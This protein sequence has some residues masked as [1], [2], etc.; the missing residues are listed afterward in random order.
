MSDRI[1]GRNIA[2][3]ATDGFEQSELDTPLDVLREAGARVDVIAPSKHPIQGLRHRERGQLVEVDDVIGNV[4]CIDYD[5][6]VIPG[7]LFSPDQ[8]RTD[9]AIIEFVRAF[10]DACKP[11]AAVCHGPWVLINACAVKGR[12]MTSVP[13]IRRDLENAGARWEDVEVDVDRGLITSRTPED[14]DAF[15]QAIITALTSDADHAS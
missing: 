10:F 5:A 9:D 1:E 6:L 4:D 13:S 11:V 3:I 15:C 8:L 2:I 14:L 12:R 7:G